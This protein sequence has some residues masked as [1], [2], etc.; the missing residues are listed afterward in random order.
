M[1]AVTFRANASDQEMQLAALAFNKLVGMLQGTLTTGLPG[2][3]TG[4][5]E[6]GPFFDEQFRRLEA[7]TL[8][9]HSIGGPAA[10][11][12]PLREKTAALLAD[13]GALSNAVG[14]EGGRLPPSLDPPIGRVFTALAGVAEALHLDTHPLERAHALIR[15]FLPHLERLPAELAARP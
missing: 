4:V 1:S 6:P 2:L 5:P 11:I 10:T 3:L 13:L 8:V 7:H 12:L 9:L 14:R 15:E